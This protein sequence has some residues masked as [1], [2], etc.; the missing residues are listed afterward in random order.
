MT[1]KDYELIAYAVKLSK[2]ES[3][4]KLADAGQNWEY[5]YE[6]RDQWS[7]TA[8]C[9]ADALQGDNPRFDRARFLRAC[10]IEP[11]AE[12]PKTTR[13]CADCAIEL[14]DTEVDTCLGCK[15]LRELGVAA[16]DIES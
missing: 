2:P 14:T 9:I 12:S 13:H 10:G 7:D 1:R 5:A 4:T 6:R 16:P 11:I 3:W 15:R 8:E